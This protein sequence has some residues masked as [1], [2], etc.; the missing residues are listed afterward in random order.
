MLSLT[1]FSAEMDRD[2]ARVR[3]HDA[4]MRKAKSGHVTGGVVFGYTNRAV[5]DGARRSHVERVIDPIEALVVR[6]IFT[7]ACDGWGVKRIAAALNAEGA[8]APLPRRAGRPRGWAPSSVRE[9]L[10]RDLYRGVVVWNRTARIVRQGARAQRDRA[11]GEVVSVTVPE[12]AIVDETLWAAAQA[13][14]QAA[15]EVYRQ[16]T[17]GRAFGRPANGVASPYLLTGLGACAVCGGSM[18]VLKRAHGSP[19]NRRQVPFYGCMTRHLRGDAI[20]HN[21]LEVL[22]EAADTAVLTAVE[23]DVLS[24]EVVETA[25]HKALAALQAPH[26]SED[27]RHTLRE[28]LAQ[29][30]A[31]IARLAQAI[32]SGGD[33][34]ALVRAMQ[35]RE[36]RCSRLKDEL[37]AVGQTMVRAEPADVARAL[38]VMRAALTDWQ[39]M[40]RQET[41]PARR[42]L[43]ALLQGRL[44]FTP[45]DCNGERF[46]TF[47]GVGTIRPVIAGTAGLQ[48]VWWPQRDMIKLTEFKCAIS[49]R[50][51]IR[52]MPLPRAAANR[53]VVH[54]SHPAC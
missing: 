21:A 8:P 23:R 49:L 51:E 6:R 48:R 22:L 18:A 17:G 38:H 9:V 19:G 27:A 5:F 54:Q 30:E 39:G 52:R 33:I 34:P 20:C 7:L 1:A 37:A 28:E 3:T 36:R 24:V 26:A 32:A 46:Y 2:R 50:A 13:R 47:E 40:L 43:Q 44:I 12:L 25:L 42:A 35:E 4:L 16:R 53:I 41:A 15:S 31:E 10:H 14:I 29:L 11:P 45:Q